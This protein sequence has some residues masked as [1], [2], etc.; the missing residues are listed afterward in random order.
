MFDLFSLEADND[1]VDVGMTDL[2]KDEADPEQDYKDAV[3]KDVEKQDPDPDAVVK[4]DL[5]MDP[6]AAT[7]EY[8]RNTFGL[9]KEDLD[10]ANDFVK[11]DAKKIKDDEDDDDEGKE[12]LEQ[13]EEKFWGFFKLKDLRSNDKRL[14][15]KKYTSI[16]DPKQFLESPVGKSKLPELK[17][18]MKNKGFSPATLEECNNLK[19]TF[20]NK[21]IRG[22]QS[23][24]IIK[25]HPIFKYYKVEGII[26]STWIGLNAFSAVAMV[27]RDK[28][29]KITS[30][31]YAI[32]I[33]KTNNGV[34]ISKESLEDKYIDYMLN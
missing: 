8:I 14:N 31:G 17:A 21:F 2:V 22:D 33:P 15:A 26:F 12:S 3:N 4:A 27:K 6:A 7:E 30:I 29:N 10:N 5:E 20:F 16:T 1:D 34:A 32:D 19:P 11:D 13:S 18:E 9:S 24:N 23:L 25:S 28:D